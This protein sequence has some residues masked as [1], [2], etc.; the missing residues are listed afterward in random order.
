LQFRLPGQGP[1]T[2]H[3][4]SWLPV[5]VVGLADVTHVSCEHC[6]CMHGSL[7]GVQSEATRQP[8]Q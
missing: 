1:V 5:Q 8:T 7:G 3:C 4:V 6:T 2:P